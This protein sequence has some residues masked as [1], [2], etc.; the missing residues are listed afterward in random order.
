MTSE[1]FDRDTKH[2]DPASEYR[3]KAAQ[4]RRLAKSFLQQEVLDTLMA[5]AAECESSAAACE[6]RA[7]LTACLGYR[8]EQTAPL[9]RRKTA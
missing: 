7:R 8:Q 5:M 3:R 6:A 2:M 4:C 9:R 1:Y